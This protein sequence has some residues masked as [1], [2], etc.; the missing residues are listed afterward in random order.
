MHVGGSS[1]PSCELGSVAQAKAWTN[2]LLERRAQR[3]AGFT[4]Q[5]TLPALDSGRI[6]S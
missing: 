1:A 4:E 5:R 6:T 2:G 3:E